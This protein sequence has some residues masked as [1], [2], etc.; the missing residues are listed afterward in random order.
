MEYYSA[1]KEEWPV[2]GTITNMDESQKPNAERM[3]PKPK[4][5]HTAWFYFYEM[6]ENSDFLYSD[7]K[8]INAGLGVAGD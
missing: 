5:A 1:V 6:L 3:K 4:K 8:L 2:S 7:Q